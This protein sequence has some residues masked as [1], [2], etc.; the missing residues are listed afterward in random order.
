IETLAPSVG[1]EAAHARV[2][3]RPD[4]NIGAVCGE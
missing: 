1:N 2:D 3:L 4:R